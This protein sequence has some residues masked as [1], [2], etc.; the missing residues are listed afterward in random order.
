MPWD[1]SSGRGSARAI[2]GR[3]AL[4][5]TRQNILSLADARPFPHAIPSNWPARLRFLQNFPASGQF[6]NSKLTALMY[7]LSLSRA[8]RSLT[9][10]FLPHRCNA[11]CRPTV[12]PV[13]L[14]WVMDGIG[15]RFERKRRELPGLESFRDPDL[16]C[17][18]QGP[19]CAVPGDP[20]IG[21]TPPPCAATAGV[22]RR[23]CAPG[24]GAP[25]GSRSQ[26]P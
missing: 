25:T 16:I 14:Q 11:D 15:R 22:D 24:R 2:L 13:Y 8:I 17:S 7:I 26:S 21:I 1:S 20:F 3:I 10:K 4:G 19:V 5:I 18:P 23:R 6:W 12:K 9:Y